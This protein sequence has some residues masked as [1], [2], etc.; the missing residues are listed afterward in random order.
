MKIDPNTIF[1]IA[2]N[3]HFN[4][5]ALAIFKFQAQNNI[6][7]NTYLTSLKIDPYTIDSIQKIPFLL[8]IYELH[9][10]KSP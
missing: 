4:Q 10:A 5:S 2:T 8:D 3:E 7:Y 1:S 6:V 9:S